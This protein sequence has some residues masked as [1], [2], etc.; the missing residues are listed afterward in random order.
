MHDPALNSQS[1]ATRSSHQLP[2]A[3]PNTPF[4]HTCQTN[5][6]LLLNLLSTYLPS[7]DSPDY[8]QRLD[9]LPEYKL[10]IYTRY[11]PVCD[12][13][14][15]AVQDE[16]RNKDHMARTK[17]LGG[18]LKESKGKDNHR[19]T[20]IS[21]KG[22]DRLS[23]EMF[24][25]RVRGILWISS[26]LLALLGYAAGYFQYPIPLSPPFLPVLVVISI[27]W[28]AWDPTYSAF[29][30]ARLQG[31]D[32]RVK[33]K[34]AYILLQ[35]TAWC[36]RLFTSTISV[37]HVLKSRAPLYFLFALIIESIAFATSL[38]ILRLQYPP[39]I[40]LINSKSHNYSFSRAASPMGNISSRATTPGI[41]LH[42]L[43]DPDLTTLS[44]SSKPIIT[45]PKPVFGHP[46]LPAVSPPPPTQPD[47]PDADEM[48]W[49]PTDPAAYSA[50][51]KRKHRSD[52]GSW[53]RPQR[54]FAPEQPTGLEGLLQKTKLTD[55]VSPTHSMIHLHLKS[56]WHLYAL[57]CIPIVLGVVYKWWRASIAK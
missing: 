7:P 36:L 48:D 39:A 44:L 2:T 9:R 6:M 8:R 16:I 14:L 42:S 51:Q 1:F 20:S 12:A 55:D 49:A 18:W 17:A 43:T 21:T 4:C 28:T 34:Q 40:R 32:V 11:P 5:Q 57:S 10:S 19:R 47:D 25:W 26:L 50:F 46:S 37:T 52:D 30:H 54:F 56:W 35:M 23:F 15:P 41:P 3:Y 38:F 22:R 31:R 27:L 29:K 13:C 45:P 33:G 24:A 53:I